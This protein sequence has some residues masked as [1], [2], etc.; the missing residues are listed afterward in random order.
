[1]LEHFNIPPVLVW[2]LLY[3]LIKIMAL[4]YLPSFVKDYWI[5]ISWLLMVSSM[6]IRSQHSPSVVVVFIQASL[7]GI[8]WL[9]TVHSSVCWAKVYRGI[10]FICYF[11]LTRKTT[12][13]FADWILF[14]R[15]GVISKVIHAHSEKQ[16]RV[17]GLNN[18][19][20]SHEFRQSAWNIYTVCR[21]YIH[22]TCVFAHF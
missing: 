22:K 21:V 3:W 5:T 15:S 1:M 19:T 7:R 6:V 20:W 12:W 4:S 14:L 9:C 8:L 11:I 2:F 18:H 13:N 10:Y 17:H 16:I